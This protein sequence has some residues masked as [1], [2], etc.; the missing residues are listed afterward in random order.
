[1]N[2]YDCIC[3]ACA[4]DRP[5]RVQGESMGPNGSLQAGHFHQADAPGE[6][7]VAV[8]ELPEDQGEPCNASE[9]DRDRDHPQAAFLDAALVAELAEPRRGG[10][11]GKEE[12]N[13][14]AQ[15]GSHHH[16]QDAADFA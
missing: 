3:A 7:A 5:Q 8:T 12:Q 9:A 15:E 13:D 2:G 10:S 14:S 4:R 6:C 16:S 1:M 11:F